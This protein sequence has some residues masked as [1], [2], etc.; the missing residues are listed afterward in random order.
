MRRVQLASLS[1]GGWGLLG[2][3]GE[4]GINFNAITVLVI[5]CLF[6]YSAVFTVKSPYAKLCG[7]TGRP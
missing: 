1:S 4:R 3:R 5:I 7:L 6:I 2:T